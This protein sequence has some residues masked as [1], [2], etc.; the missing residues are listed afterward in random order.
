MPL[1][2]SVRLLFT[3]V[4]LRDM[5]AKLRQHGGIL[6]IV[7]SPFSSPTYCLNLH[8]CLPPAPPHKSFPS[9]CVPLPGSC[10]RHSP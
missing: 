10:S 9:R 5:L 2:N 3:F 7:L 4:Y 1:E 6:A 8:V